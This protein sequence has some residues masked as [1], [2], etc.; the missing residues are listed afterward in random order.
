MYRVLL[1]VDEN[2]PRASEQIDALLSLPADADELSVTVLHVFEGIDRSAETLGAVFVDDLEETIPES[3]AVPDSVTYAVE[4]LEEEGIEPE[5]KKMVG[6]PAEGILQA[7][8]EF[9]ADLLLLGIQKRSP[10]GKVVFG[11]VSQETI[12]DT[13]R[14]VMVVGPS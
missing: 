1:P 10:V 9:D 3:R 8:D 2:E 11:S 5:V 13:D 6:E 7:A 4:R 14:N 12:L